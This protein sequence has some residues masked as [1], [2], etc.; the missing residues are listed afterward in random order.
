MLLLLGA[1]A[2]AK[3]VPAP[4]ATLPVA[5]SGMPTFERRPLA[6]AEEDLPQERFLMFDVVSDGSVIYQSSF[7][8]GPMLRRIDSTG[9]LLEAFGREGEGPG[10]LRGLAFLEVRGD[11]L[12]IYNSERKALID[13][14]LSGKLL[15]ERRIE[16]FDSRL[17]WHPDS[18]DHWNPTP[19]PGRERRVLRSKIGEEGGRVLF[20][21]TSPAFGTSITKRT[22]QATSP[23]LLPY[24]ATADRMWLA[25][26]WEYR[27]SIFSNDGAPINSF[28][29]AIARNRFGPRALAETRARIMKAHRPPR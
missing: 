22:G 21:S 11:T 18:V 8:K 15:R 29:H 28:V 24:T 2:C 4:P 20:D 12:Q 25:D 17:V 7:D 16:G 19:I 23:T 27:I 5:G 14:T 3:E 1:M 26:P 13:M 9:R 10:E 6:I